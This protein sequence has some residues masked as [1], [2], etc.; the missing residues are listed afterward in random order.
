MGLRECETRGPVAV[1][2]DTYGAL[3]QSLPKEMRPQIS[4]NGNKTVEVDYSAYHIRMLYHREGI[5]FREDP[6]VVCEGPGMRKEYKAVGLIAINAKDD[7]SAYGAI[8][9]EFI[10]NKIPFPAG[11][12]PLVHLVETFKEVHQPIAKYLFSDI[13]VHLQNIDSDI[14]DNIL[15]RLLDDGILGL[16]VY[17]SVIVDTKYEEDLRDTMER[18]YEAVMSYKPVF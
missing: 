12:K 2:C 3:H 7:Q 11:E 1:G 4:I 15:M 17:D 13:G 18:E 16:S 14:M 8:R 10:K 6:Y 5:D 9:D